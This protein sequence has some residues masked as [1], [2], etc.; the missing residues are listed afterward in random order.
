[1]VVLLALSKTAETKINKTCFVGFGWICGDTCLSPWKKYDKCFC[2]GVKVLYDSLVWCCHSGPCEVTS[3]GMQEWGDH[4]KNV[5]CPGTVQSLDTTCHGV[6]NKET[7]GFKT[8]RSRL[9]CDKKKCVKDNNMC[10][11]RQL[12]ED[13]TDLKLCENE[14]F[15]ATPCPDTQ[16][17]RCNLRFPGQCVQKEL[18]DDETFHCLDRSDEKPFKNQNTRKLLAPPLEKCSDNFNNKGFICK[19]RSTLFF[20]EDRTHWCSER[21]N[22]VCR[23]LGDRR[24]TDMDICNNHTFWSQQTCPE[25]TYPCTG[26]NNG[27]CAGSDLSTCN[28]KSDQ[29]FSIGQPCNMSINDGTDRLNCT[30]S[31]LRLGFPNGACSN[32][33]YPR[34]AKDMKCYEPSL[35]CDLHPTCSDAEDEKDCLQTYKKRN[36]IPAEAFFPCMSPH[37]PNTVEILA[38]RCNSVSECY[39]GLDEK[40]CKEE[41]VEPEVLGKKYSKLIAKIVNGPSSQ[42]F[43]SFEPFTLLEKYYFFSSFAFCAHIHF[44]GDI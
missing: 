15:R 44:S 21:H 30:G 41:L 38:V 39:Q 31:C 25:G 27:Q 40:D 19:G 42:R 36:F 20:C 2:G 22:R 4:I 24:M 11:G 13:E 43:A 7:D 26:R 16:T 9:L 5:S 32:P 28:D 35:R 37:Y 17:W 3:L 29:I 34:C 10:A 18:K 23:N 8:I 33:E 6:C 1:M 12:C 14:E